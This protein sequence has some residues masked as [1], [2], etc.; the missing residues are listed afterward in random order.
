MRQSSNTYSFFDIKANPQHLLIF[1]AL[2]IFAFSLFMGDASI[3]I[4]LHDTYFV[5]AYSLLYRAIAVALLI[6]WACYMVADKLLPLIALRWLHVLITTLFSL[7][8]IIKTSMFAGLSGAPRRYYA[9]AE[10]G[11]Q[12]QR[13]YLLVYLIA[14]LLIGQLFLIANLITGVIRKLTSS[15]AK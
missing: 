13:T 6:L 2:L 1:L 14:A 10:F 12:M 7:I 9:F 15:P 5:I 8:F 3:D 11:Q 4:N